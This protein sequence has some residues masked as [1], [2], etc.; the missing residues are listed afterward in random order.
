LRFPSLFRRARIAGQAVTDIANWREVLPLAARGQDV[1][2]IRLRN[3]AVIHAPADASLWPHFSDIWYH[4][5]YTKHCSIKSGAVVV[6]VGANAGVFS[7]FAARHARQVYALEPA[8]SNFSQLIQNVRLARNVVALQC[9]CGARDGEATLDLSGPPVTYSLKTSSS[10]KSESVKVV[11][12]ETLFRRYHIAQCDYL[13]LDCEG[14]EFEIIL[15]AVPSVFSRVRQ[16]VLEYHDHLSNGASHYDLAEK[17]RSFGFETNNY[18]P[19]GTHG[20]MAA[21]RV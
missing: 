6:D 10:G 13:K 1:T 2:E 19:N 8:S 4:S 5:S 20:M 3:G 12:L 14:A 17:L 21:V 16:I 7:L 18:N 11:C 9:A 15:E